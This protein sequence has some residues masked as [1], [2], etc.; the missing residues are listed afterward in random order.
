[1]TYLVR[2]RPSFRPAAVALVL[3]A[4][5]AASG[6]APDPTAPHT[7]APTSTPLFASDEEA[8]AAAEEAYAAYVTLTDEILAS[9]GMGVERLDSVA[10]GRQ[11]ETD[12]AELEELASLG[13]RAIGST[14]ISDF[15]LQ[16]YD[17]QSN[18]GQS[19]V[20]AYVCEDVSDV[21]IVDPSGESVVEPDRPNR[22]KYALTF[23]STDTKSSIL[24]LSS[25]EPWVRPEC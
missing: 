5:L 20:T 19:V 13:Y 9:G 22:V 3:L 24:L 11:L 21:D 25:R 16:A 7:P 6:C 1:M 12:T 10:T 2:M 15:T 8:L 14:A 23:D 17:R 4:A 18:M